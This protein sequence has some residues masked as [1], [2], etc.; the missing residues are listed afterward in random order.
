LKLMAAIVVVGMISTEGCR[1]ASRPQ[2]I[3]SAG[4]GNVNANTLG[5]STES[6]TNLDDFMDQNIAEGNPDFSYKGLRCALLNGKLLQADPGKV[7]DLE[8]RSDK[9]CSIE[10]RV[11]YTV[12]T[13]TS[14]RSHR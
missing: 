8:C 10:Q 13:T 6:C 2:I 11:D 1:N 5:A 4:S 3:N 14:A 9:A 7:L 12:T